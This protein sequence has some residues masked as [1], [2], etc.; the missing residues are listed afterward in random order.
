MSAY[1]TLECNIVDL[2]C[3]IEALKLL[4]LEA[5]IYDKV[6]GKWEVMGYEVVLPFKNIK[7]MLKWLLKRLE[8][9][10]KEGQ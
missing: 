9:H 2:D 7:S 1:K 5:K 10:E 8:K 4:G 6:D 3:L